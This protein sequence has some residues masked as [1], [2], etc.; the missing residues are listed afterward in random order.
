YGHIHVFAIGRRAPLTAAQHSALAYS[1]LPDNFTLLVRVQGMSHAGLLPD[2][3][4]PPPVGE[5]DQNRGLS[6][7]RIRSW[8]VRTIRLAWR[9]AASVISIT[10][11]HLFRPQ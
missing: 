10:R 1:C 9:V 7:I 8:R 4:G 11:G 3:Q 2:D 5:R 6:K